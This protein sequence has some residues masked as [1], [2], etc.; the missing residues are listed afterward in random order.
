L[1]DQYPG[2][3][4]SVVSP[5]FGQNAQ[6]MTLLVKLARKNKAKVLM[7]WAAR[8]DKGKGYELNIKPVNILSSTGRVED[9]VAL[10]NQAIEQLVKTKP[11]QYLW[12]YKRFK[13]IVRY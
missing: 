1:P 10:M 6:T 9:D 13:G 8:L 11:E 5:F 12:N 4:G 7:A 2:E 3:K